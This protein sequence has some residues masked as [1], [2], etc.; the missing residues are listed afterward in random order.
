MSKKFIL[1]TVLFI[2]F[3]FGC[4]SPK[5]ETGLIGI[6]DS[7]KVSN[8]LYDQNYKIVLTFYE[9]SVITESFGGEHKTN[10]NWTLDST[11]LYFSAIRLLDTVLPNITYEYRINKT[12]DSLS[13]K[14]S[15]INK[16]DYTV[17]FKKVIANPFYIHK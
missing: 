16:E 6:W 15:P 1:L 8:N 10:S 12:K 2:I 4:S 9:D 5:K 7:Y 11:K 14:V 13:I 3:I 17:S